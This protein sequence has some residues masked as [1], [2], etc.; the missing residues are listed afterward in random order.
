[1]QIDP[2]KYN[3][4]NLKIFKHVIDQLE[5]EIGNTNLLDTMLSIFH[6]GK[7]D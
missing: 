7:T 1:M 3:N 4:D 2:I 6:A 5:P